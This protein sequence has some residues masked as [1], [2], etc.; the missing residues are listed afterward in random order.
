MDDMFFV[1]IDFDRVKAFVD[2]CKKGFEVYGCILNI[3]KMFLNFDYGED[4]W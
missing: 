4:V 1:I 2:M 3:I